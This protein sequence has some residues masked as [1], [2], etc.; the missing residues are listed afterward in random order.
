MNTTATI[1]ATLS[2]KPAQGQQ[3]AALRAAGLKVQNLRDAGFAWAKSQ[4]WVAPISVRARQIVD[5]L[6]NG[7]PVTP[8]GHDEAAVIELEDEKADR[9]SIE[10]IPGKRTVVGVPTHRV[11]A[12]KVR[13]EK[14]LPNLERERDSHTQKKMA[15]MMN[16]RQEAAQIREA[17]AVIDLWLAAPTLPVPDENHFLRAVA[18]ESVSVP[19][20]YH[21][22]YV[23]NGKLIATAC[24]V[25]NGLRAMVAK[26]GPVA[27]PKPDVSV[28]EAQT[29]FAHIPGFF[30]TPDELVQQM[31][32]AADLC[33]GDVVLEPSAGKGDIAV[34]VKC[35]G[36]DVEC[37]EVEGRLVEILKAKHLRVTQGDFLAM[38]AHA[39]FDAVLMNPPFEKGAD[40]DHVRHAFG[41]VKEGGKLVAIV[42]AGALYRQDRKA[43]E[44]RAW[45]D[46]LGAEITDNG[47]AFEKAFKRTGVA[48]SLV[49]IVKGEG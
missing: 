7:S 28:M 34:A 39:G 38:P 3:T 15:Q 33:A 48:T 25:I 26:A 21:S 36:A 30:P 19:N 12:I 14:R 37:V 20:G 49:V 43:T 13:L 32:E 45:L 17:L 22:Y 24:P 4:A 42:S 11:L 5:A 41:F 40:I 23:R 31:I 29:K 27:E 6:T 46:E 16:A 35:A 2:W 44:F 1:P 18:Q 9:Q 10:I 8:V 47:A